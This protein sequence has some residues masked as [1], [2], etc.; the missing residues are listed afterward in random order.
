MSA[1]RACAPW[2]VAAISSEPVPAKGSYTVVPGRACTMLVMMNDSS[3]SMDVGPMKGRFLQENM[4]AKCRCPSPSR[5]PRKRRFTGRSSRARAPHSVGSPTS[6]SKHSCA[7]GSCT[8]TGPR[9]SSEG[10]TR[11][12]HASFSERLSLS[13]KKSTS[14]AHAVSSPLHAATEDG[15]RDLTSSRSCSTVSPAPHSS[16]MRRHSTI[17]AHTARTTSMLGRLSKMKGEVGSTASWS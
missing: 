8:R 1:P 9:R 3:A 2:C 14:M 11:C 4:S 17:R 7:S 10:I 5:R 6:P 12:R 15:L 16:M 13:P